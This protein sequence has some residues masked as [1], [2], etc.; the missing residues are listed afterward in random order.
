MSKV[1]AFMHVSL[2]GFVAGPNGEMNWIQASPELFEFVGRRIG[3]TDT[4]L[5]GRKTFQMMEGYWP[6]ADQQPNATAHDLEHARWYRQVRKVVV[7]KLL[8]AAPNS[9]VQVI[10][11]DLIWEVEELKRSSSHEIL[12]FGSPTAAH[13]LMAQNLIDGY[14]LFVNPVL[15]GQGIPIF[16]N[17]G[18]TT[19][20]RLL[21]TMKLDSGVIALSYERTN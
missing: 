5:Y 3:Q 20:L 12:L 17:I 8:V 2:D 10:G 13:S 16:Q 18:A 19:G 7:S 9:N 21:D 1:I 11:S 14:W 4:A 15:L 6:T